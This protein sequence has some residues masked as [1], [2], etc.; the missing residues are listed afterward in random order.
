[1][2]NGSI[3]AQTERGEAKFGRFQRPAVT[4]FKL[5]ETVELSLSSQLTAL[6]FIT[7]KNIH[8][9]RCR[10]PAETKSGSQSRCGTTIS[11]P[12]STASISLKIRN[13]LVPIGVSNVWISEHVRSEPLLLSRAPLARK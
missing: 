11:R 12:L 9:G 4:K 5:H 7:Q 6:I 13:L 3:S 2:A 8:C 10:P 1:M